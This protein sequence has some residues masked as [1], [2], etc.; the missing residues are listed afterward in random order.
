M[1]IA[2]A[3]LAKVNFTR[4]QDSKLP[5]LSEPGSVAACKPEV[6]VK[7]MIDGATFPAKVAWTKWPYGILPASQLPSCVICSM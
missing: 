2:Q 4:S 7:L 1:S 5:G 3:L 6:K